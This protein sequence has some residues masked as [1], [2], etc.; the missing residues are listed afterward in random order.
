MH[1][2]KT[3]KCTKL[4]E[5]KHAMKAMKADGRKEAPGQSLHMQTD[6]QERYF[7][8]HKA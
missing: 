7:K 4:E 5:E 1:K 2:N 6:Y 3:K 8:N